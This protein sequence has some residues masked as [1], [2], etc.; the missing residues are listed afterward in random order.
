MT[1][2]KRVNPIEV[3]HKYDFYNITDKE[4]KKYTLYAEDYDIMVKILMETDETDPEQANDGYIKPQALAEKVC[5][6]Y[7]SLRTKM[8]RPTGKYYK[9]YHLALKVLDYYRYIDYYKDGTIK[10]HDKF[11]KITPTTHQYGLSKWV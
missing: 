1:E 5:E 7:P 4:G 8:L 11:R 3:E 9:K 6:L 2:K 10:K